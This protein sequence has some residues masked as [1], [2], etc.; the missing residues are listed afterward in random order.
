[1]T[2]DTFTEKFTVYTI[3]KCKHCVNAKML[4]D[5]AGYHYDEYNI[6]RDVP[7]EKLQERVTAAGSDV[8]VTTAPQIFHGKRYIGGATELSK[9]LGL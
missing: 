8:V 5:A 7:K 6:P 4:L 2:R 3:D 9:Y 1:M